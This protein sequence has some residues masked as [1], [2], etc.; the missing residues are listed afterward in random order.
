M[1]IYFALFFLTLIV[2][3]PLKAEVIK[4]IQITGMTKTKPWALLRR[5]NVQIGDDLTLQEVEDLRIRVAQN[6]QFIVNSF[7]FEEG[8]LKIDIEDKWTII[9]VPLLS[10]SG[11]YYMRGIGLFENNFLGRL[12]TLVPAVAYT[13]SGINYLLLYNS[14]NFFTPNLGISSLIVR[15]NTLSRFYRHKVEQTH[16]ESRTTAFEITPNY[17]YK[18][19]VFKAGPIFFKKDVIFNNTSIAQKYNGAGLRSRFN[20]KN[21]EPMDVMFKGYFVTANSYILK[22]D[23]GKGTFV[24]A[25]I[26]YVAT[27]PV[28]DN[29][30][31]NFSQ[32]F[33]YATAKTFFY[34]F[35]EGAHD[36]FRGY[37]GESLHM[38]RYSASMLQFQRHVWDRLY[39]IGF[40]E[41]THS[42][43]INPINNGR[44]LNEQTVGTGLRYYLKK[45]SIPGINVEYGYNIQDKSSHVHFNVGLKL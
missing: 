38:Q 5:V 37:D 35:S 28:L 14:E 1:R 6:S 42:V 12:E 15:L 17:F 33:G 34:Q 29:A 36:G 8:I 4:D 24:H 19:M 26:E 10:Q 32:N 39:A 41:N 13:N 16:F 7:K 20:I 44:H 9:P 27:Y 40:V 18:N 23:T 3:Q 31:V 11:D 43:S 22:P 25:K 30:F 2:A 21:Y 45:I